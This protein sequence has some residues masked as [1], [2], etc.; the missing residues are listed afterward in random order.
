M[1]YSI[2]RLLPPPPLS[3]PVEG[4]QFFETGSRAWWLQDA[5]LRALKGQAAEPA[6]LPRRELLRA[7]VLL[8]TRGETLDLSRIHARAARGRLAVSKKVAAE[9]PSAPDAVWLASFR[10]ERFLNEWIPK[11]KWDIY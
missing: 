2:L 1:P 3:V 8:S 4:L 5:C 6:D 9:K 7:P 10:D 11:D